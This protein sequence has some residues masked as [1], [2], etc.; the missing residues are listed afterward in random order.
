MNKKLILK[1]ATLNEYSRLLTVYL[2]LCFCPTLYAETNQEL[3]FETNLMPLY[4]IIVLI[5]SF[6]LFLKI[7]KGFLK[8]HPRLLLKSLYTRIDF[9]VDNDS[10]FLYYPN[11]S[12]PHLKLQVED[13]TQSEIYLNDQ[14]INKINGAES[15]RFNKNISN[16]MQNAFNIE[17]RFKMVDKRIRKIHIVITCLHSKHTVCLYLREGNQRLTKDKYQDVIEFVDNWCQLIAMQVNPENAEAP[18]ANKAIVE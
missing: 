5:S 3:V 2:T 15:N 9:N 11:Q 13:I 12:K 6:F 10:V 7:K 4:W 14:L 16:T 1:T 18:T 8:S 17:S